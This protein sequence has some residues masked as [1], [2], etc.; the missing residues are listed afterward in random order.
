VGIVCHLLQFKGA[1]AS[2]AM[3][4]SHETLRIDVS[5]ISAKQDT[6]PVV[7]QLQDRRRGGLAYSASFLGWS[8]AALER[9]SFVL[10]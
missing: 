9:P 2:L 4:S 3:N 7:W 10:Y 8:S 5:T 6:V 1:D